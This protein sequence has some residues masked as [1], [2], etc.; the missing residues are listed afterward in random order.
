MKHCF[1]TKVT[2]FKL[3]S[4]LSGH[5]SWEDKNEHHCQKE[6]NFEYKIMYWQ[7]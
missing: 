3:L 1:I 6:M 7:E 2:S 5:I 4:Y